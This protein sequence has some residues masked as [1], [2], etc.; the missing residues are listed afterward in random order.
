MKKHEPTPPTEVTV[1]SI[2]DIYFVG[3]IVR[4]Y[5]GFNYVVDIDDDVIRRI[6]RLL[7]DGF[8][9]SPREVREMLTE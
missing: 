3:G 7:E 8:T 2:D 4:I 1:S 5:T 6:A 9:G